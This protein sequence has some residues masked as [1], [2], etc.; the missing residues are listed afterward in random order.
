MFRQFRILILLW[1]LLL[2]AVSGWLTK[3]RATD[4]REPLHVAVY[5][6][7]GDGSDRAGSYIE[8]LTAGSF[9]PIEGY[10]AEQAA[11]YGVGL[12]DVVDIDLA[13]QVQTIPPAAPQ[14]GGWW[15]VGAWSLQLRYWA[16]RNDPYDGPTPD[17][18]LYVLYFDPDQNPRLA[19]SLGLQKTMTGV[20][21]AFADRRMEGSNQVVM[22]HELLHTLGATDKYDPAS[23]QPTFPFGYAEPDLQPRFPQRYAEIMGGR[24]PRSPVEAEIPR[25]LRETRIGP[26]T[27]QE[28]NWARAL[29]EAVGTDNH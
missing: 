22:T 10:L 11:D 24:I 25:S 21:N 29:S 19:H 2:V 6:I 28:I 3:M 5:P 17:I 7:N 23:N 26:A 4:W 8:Q 27:A 14:G 13:P 18:K 12:R 15:Q 16:W 1:V 9:E 20:I